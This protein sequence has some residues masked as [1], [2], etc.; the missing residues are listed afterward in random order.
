MLTIHHLGSPLYV[1]ATHHDLLTIINGHRW[2]QLR[3]VIICTEDAVAPQSLTFALNNLNH[4]LIH[5]DSHSDLLRFVRV[6]NLD[7]FSEL[8]TRPGIEKI[9]GFVFPKCDLTNIGE[10]LALLDGSNYACMPIL[11]TAAAFDPIQMIALR[12]Y[13]MTHPHR[14][15]I[16]ALRIGGNDLFALLDI[17]RPRD[18]TIYHTPLGQAI[19]QLVTIFKPYG[20]QLTA[21]VFEHI[22]MPE[23]LAEELRDDRAYGLASKAAIHP[24]QVS[25]IHAGYRISAEELETARRVLTADHAVFKFAGSMCEVSTLHTWATHIIEQATLTNDTADLACAINSNHAER[26]YWPRATGTS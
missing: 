20:F 8:L 10:Y 5:A 13:L 11:E 12:D 18:R 23:L 9:A 2:P 14:Q 7:V 22:D 19:A 1:P 26:N 6:R 25:M 21:P 3:S 4:A 15:K 17:R 16:L 24:H